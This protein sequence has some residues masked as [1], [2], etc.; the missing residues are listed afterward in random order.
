MDHR[1][2]DE[3]Y[4]V[5]DEAKIIE[6]IKDCIIENEEY[7]CP[8]DD[9][10]LRGD[11]SGYSV[12]DGHVHAIDLWD[13]PVKAIP[14][15]ICALPELEILVIHSGTI[16]HLP[17]NIGRLTN[18]DHLEVG[19]NRLTYLPESLGRLE[20]LRI[21]IIGPNRISELPKWIGALKHLEYLRLEHNPIEEIPPE[22][23]ALSRLEYFYLEGLEIPSLPQEMGQLKSLKK[24]SIKKCPISRLPDTLE[25]LADLKDLSL[26]GTNLKKMPEFLG[27]LEE[28]EIC[29]G[30]LSLLIESKDILSDIPHLHKIHPD[31]E[32]NLLSL[33]TKPPP[34][35]VRRID[36]DLYL[37]S[38]WCPRIVV[39]R[40]KQDIWPL[41]IDTHH[42][43]LPKHLRLLLRKLAPIKTDA[44]R[45]YR[46]FL[47]RR[48]SRKIKNKGL[49]IYL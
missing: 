46:E 38:S 6:K 23:G 39:G 42:P 1:E 44:A 7:F 5:P 18:L 49:R 29:A 43:D 4:L 36:Y 14:D 37:L 3:P 30:D 21:L 28:L 32:S 26:L 2:E 19:E 48:F 22:I 15:E 17:E 16:S 13:I 27:G 45:E 12:F 31:N 20:G 8:F 9:L 34:P 24:L 40:L 25:R 41:Y 33:G 10:L 35:Y 11:I 47:N